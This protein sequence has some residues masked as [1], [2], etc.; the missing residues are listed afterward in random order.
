MS[1]GTAHPICRSFTG[2]D[3][4]AFGV[5]LPSLVVA[6]VPEHHDGWLEI[7]NYCD[8]ANQNSANRSRLDAQTVAITARHRVLLL[9]KF[10]D[11]R[12]SNW[13][14]SRMR[15]DHTPYSKKEL[16]CAVHRPR[17]RTEYRQYQKQ[18]RNGAQHF[19]YNVNPLH[20]ETS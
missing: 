4:L 16:P 18:K 2:N 17:Q 19:G 11:L 6:T 20:R 7:I 1:M 14:L 5:D 3:H 9:D 10:G 15:S 12:Q 13:R 8:F